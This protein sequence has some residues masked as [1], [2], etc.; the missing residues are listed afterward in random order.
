MADRPEPRRFQEIDVFRGIAALWVVL[1]HFVIRYSDLR[2]SPAAEPPIVTALVAAVA[3]ALPDFGLLPVWWFFMISGFVITWTLERCRTWRDF[4][5]SRATRLYPVYWAA[6]TLTFLAGTLWP[7]AGQS[8]SLRQFVWNLSMV[9][10]IFN[11]AHIDGVLHLV[12][13][14]WALAC[15][16]NHWLAVHGIDVWWLVQKYALLRQGHFLIAGI[17]FYQLWRGRRPVLSGAILL[18]CLISIFLAYPVHEGLVCSGFFAAFGLA[19]RNRARFIV[20]RRL[21]WLGSISYALYLSHELLGWRLMLALETLAVPRWAAILAAIAMALTLAHLLTRLV[22]WPARDALR[23][24]RSAT[25]YP[26]KSSP[27]PFP[28][29]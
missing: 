7:L 15:L 28:R 25:P 18:L 13:L 6:V 3:R 22:E 14:G 29:S 24:W 16:T 4:A 5:I 1:F 8:Y 2:L 21:V 20:N 26:V 12:C 10:E 17:M 19:I 9:Q 11:V 27:P 23:A